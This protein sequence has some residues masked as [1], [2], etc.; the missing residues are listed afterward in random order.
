M[1]LLGTLRKVARSLL[2]VLLVTF[3]VVAL[4]S[5]APG[6][7]ATVILGPAATPESVAALN[8]ELG[9]N[10]SVFVQYWDWLT[11]ALHGDL[12]TSLLTDLPVTETIWERL[13]VTLELALL[14]QVIALGIAV[15][16]AIAAAARP[17]S[18]VDRFTSAI[19]SASLSIPA[20]VAAPILVY[21]LALQ[22]DLF[23]VSGWNDLSEGIGP[24]LESALL[25][26][27]A[28]ALAEIAAF[29]RLLRT[30]LVSTLREDY[31]AA[32]R[33]K[34][35]SP[36]FVML[37]H[38]LRPSSFSLIT[39]LAISTGRLLGGTVIVETLFSLPGLGSLVVNSITSRDVVV[40]QGVVAF[41]AVVYVALNT[42]VDVGYGLLDPRVR[43]EARA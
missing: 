16:L 21:F 5:L 29:Q 3:M 13:P 22:L 19:S 8:E 2:V 18:V 12:G 6:S 4:L 14:A 11:N 31:I 38:A 33:A 43:K 41:I 30:D 39:L 17:G 27:F 42:A 25:P 28:I 36:T 34:G 26:A 10:D 24:N 7:V 37:R 40:V 9:L 1:T 32:A 35:M 20:F 15:P 23:P